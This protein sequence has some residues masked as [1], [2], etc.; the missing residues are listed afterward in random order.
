MIKLQP[1]SFTDSITDDGQELTRL[2]Y[3][4]VAD[5]VSGQV[6]NNPLISRVVGFVGD[7]KRQEVDLWWQDA[8]TGDLS[9]LVGKYVVVQMADGG[10]S[11][12]ATDVQ[13]A[14]RI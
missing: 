5:D 3:P 7:V 14:V 6:Q 8:R 12:L 4:V 2:P 9:E 1:A 13:S 11:T 10:L